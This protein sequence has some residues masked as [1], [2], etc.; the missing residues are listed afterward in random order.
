[1][2]VTSGA[3]FLPGPIAPESITTVFGKN[4]TTD[5]MA[6]SGDPSSLPTRS[7]GESTSV[8][9]QDSKGV[10]RLAQLYYVSPAQINFLVPAAT[11]LGL[12]KVSV[13]APIRGHGGA[14]QSAQ[15]ERCAGLFTVTN[16]GLAAANGIHV[17]AG[18]QYA[19]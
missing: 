2:T 14:G 5:T 7:C 16:D 9:I 15:Y 18:V 4:L 19:S 12:A 1:M 6:A 3:S 11:A 13:T 17:Q 8:T 10:S